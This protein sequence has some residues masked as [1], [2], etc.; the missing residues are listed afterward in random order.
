M[1]YESTYCRKDPRHRLKRCRGKW[2]P[3]LPSCL[4][5]CV[6]LLDVEVAGRRYTEVDGVDEIFERKPVEPVQLCRY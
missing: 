4:L 3:L 6:Q 1:I 5:V 2:S